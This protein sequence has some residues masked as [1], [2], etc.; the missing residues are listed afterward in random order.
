MWVIILILFLLILY[1]VLGGR[2]I[3]RNKSV[4]GSSVSTRLDFYSTGMDSGFVLP[5]IN[6]MWAA[7]KRISLVT[8]S[9]IFGSLSELDKI[10]REMS[11]KENISPGSGTSSESVLL[12]KLLKYR[13]KLELDKSRNRSGIKST[14]TIAVGHK[15]YIRIET[16]A[17]YTSEVIENEPE[18]LTIRIPSGESL[19][20]DFSWRT[21][22]L[23]I[24]LWREDDAGYFFQ[25]HIIQD[26]YDLKKLH[27]RIHHSDKVLRRQRRESLRRIV[28]IRAGF[29]VMDDSHDA[30]QLAGKEQGRVCFIENLSTGGAR[31]RTR[32]R[33]KKQQVIKLE[34]KLR[35]EYLVIPGVIL[36][37]RQSKDNSEY[38]SNIEFLSYHKDNA[39]DILW[40]ILAPDNLDM[41]GKE[42]WQNNTTDDNKD[43]P[44]TVEKK[45][46]EDLNSI[47]SAETDEK[48]GILNTD[49][50]LSL[51]NEQSGNTG[52]NPDRKKS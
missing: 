44:N 34:L 5:E 49:S 10:I 38:I 52:Q 45:S 3:T 28:S 41:D 20:P 6:L 13:N 51:F 17:I 35:K 16:G 27:F 21:R 37:C 12:K 42:D 36:R 31:I 40:Y 30:N 48:T 8:P 33:L 14:R 1:F 9:R 11:C 25:S 7:A 2:G 50:S 18:H 4:N 24:Y 47:S 23:N 15:L 19:P 39:I 26:Y 32:E 22:T 46:S 43:L 29:H